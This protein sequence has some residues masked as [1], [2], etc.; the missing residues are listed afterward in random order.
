MVVAGRV[1]V[2]VVVVE[3]RRV[4]RKN[5]GRHE[6]ANEKQNGGKRVKFG[7]KKMAGTKMAGTKYNMAGTEIISAARARR[8][9]DVRSIAACISST[10]QRDAGGRRMA[11]GECTA[12]AAA[13]WPSLFIQVK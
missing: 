11:M 4:N 3:V 6:M 9:V 8:D 5:C 12:V 7:G 1:A 2:L 13:G 10:A